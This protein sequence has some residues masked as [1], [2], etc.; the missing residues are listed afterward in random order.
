MTAP[1]TC[2]CNCGG[3]TA[4]LSEEPLWV[5]QCWC[6][7][8]QK[9]AAGSPTNNALF[10]TSAIGMRGELAWFSYA[11]ESGNIIEQGYCAAC[12]TPVMG[13]NSSRPQACVIRLGFIDPPHEL[14]PDSAIWLD[15]APAWAAIDPAL[16]HFPRQPPL[17]PRKD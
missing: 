17:P 5:R 10:M 15:E 6:R 2:S 12:G 13:R 9:A 11:A 3:L 14:R 1:Y 16:E 7:Q 8:C 4:T